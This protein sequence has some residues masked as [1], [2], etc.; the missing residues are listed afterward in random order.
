VRIPKSLASVKVAIMTRVHAT[1][2]IPAKLQKRQAD[3]IARVVKLADQ[4]STW[5]EAEG[6]KVERQQKR[7]NEELL[8][9][10]SVPEI[11]VRLK[12]GQ[13]ILTPVA[14]HV[15]GGDGRVDLEAIPTLARIKLVWVDGGWKLYAD[16]NV[17]LRLAWNQRNFAQLAHDLLS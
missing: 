16:P 5:S 9:T 11:T 7:I 2:G 1:A 12:G 6:W 17:P 13:L 14:L 10:Y 3:W 4:V 8:G 15:T